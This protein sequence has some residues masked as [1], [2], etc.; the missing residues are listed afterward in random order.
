MLCQVIYGGYDIGEITC[1]TLYADDSS[2]VDFFNS[3]VYGLGVLKMSVLFRLQRWG[4]I[5]CSLYAKVRA[6]GIPPNLVP[7]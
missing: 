5:D 3:V 7:N 1:P 2:S 4:L 6:R